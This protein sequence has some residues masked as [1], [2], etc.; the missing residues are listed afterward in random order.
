MSKEKSVP[1]ISPR[2]DWRDP[3]SYKSL[4]DLA[5]AG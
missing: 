1:G 4:V 5:R 3:A 2:A